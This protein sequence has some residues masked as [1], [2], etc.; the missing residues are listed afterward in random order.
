MLGRNNKM[1]KTGFL[2]IV[3]LA[4]CVNV[5]AGLA[6]ADTS[7]DIPRITKKELRAKLD[8][9][10]VVII[11]VR[12]PKNWDSSEKKIKGAIRENPMDVSHWYN[13]PKDKI[14]VLYC[15]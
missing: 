6:K 2:I 4:I 8:N 5:V 14:M 1:N 12:I 15:A 11:D 7:E 13:Y 10:D 3:I 9:D